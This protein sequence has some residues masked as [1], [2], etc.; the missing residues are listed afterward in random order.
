M[1]LFLNPSPVPCQSLSAATLFSGN[2]CLGHGVIGSEA[3]APPTSYYYWCFPF[4]N[5]L[6]PTTPCI[7]IRPRT[8]STPYPFPFVGSY[9]LSLPLLACGFCSVSWAAVHPS[10]RPLS[11]FLLA[12]ASNRSHPCTRQRYS[13]NVAVALGA[14]PKLGYWDKCP[15]CC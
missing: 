3:G 2:F 10:G 8:S 5:P 11:L 9:S 1:Y 7:P 4:V 13:Y 6:Y 15:P 12:A 14:V